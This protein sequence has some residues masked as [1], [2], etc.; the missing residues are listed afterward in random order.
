MC[1]SRFSIPLDAGSQNVTLD[2]DFPF[3]AADQVRVVGMD[4][5]EFG[6]RF[7]VFGYENALRAN[8]IEQRQT[9]FLELRG[10]Y[11]FRSLRA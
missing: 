10:G 5:H 2:F 1:V 7:A 6:D 11:G 8:S 4:G 9:L 3:E